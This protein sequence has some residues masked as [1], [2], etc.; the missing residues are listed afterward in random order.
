MDKAGKEK[1][2]ELIGGHLK[3]S[4]LAMCADYRGLTVDEITQLRAALTESGAFGRVVKNTLAK[5]SI[6]QALTDGSPEQVEKFKELFS[7]PS[8]V[9]F[10]EE[11][12]AGPAKVMTKFAKEHENLEIKGGWFEGN[13]LEIDGIKELSDLPSRDEL[14]AKLLSILSAPATKVVQLLQAPGSKLVQ[15]LEAQR[16]KLESQE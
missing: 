6:D 3:K 11:D 12:P 5:V 7:G 16:Q 13:C 4:V 9:V 15:T 1:E 8:F 14:Y 10:S 2:V